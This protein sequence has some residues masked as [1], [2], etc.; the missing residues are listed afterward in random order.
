MSRAKQYFCSV[1]IFRYVCAILVVM[2]HTHP[3]AFGD[4]DS[5]ADAFSTDCVARIAVP[6]F[7]AVSGYFFAEKMNGDKARQFAIFRKSFWN[8]LRIYL[9][10]SCIYAVF[11]FCVWGKDD[12][13]GFLKNTVTD[14]FIHGSHF[15]FWYFTALLF[16]ICFA[17]LFYCLNLEKVA[18]ALGLALYLAYCFVLPAFPDSSVS[19]VLLKDGVGVVGAD[20][21]C[22]FLF[23]GFPYFSVGLAVRWI[24]SRRESKIPNPI[25][26][27]VVPAVAVG[28]AATWLAARRWDGIYYGVALFSVYPLV[29]GILLLFLQNSFSRGARVAGACRK[30]AN[31]T[32]YSHPILIWI[33]DKTLGNTAFLPNSLVKFL[34][35]A[36]VASLIGWAVFKINRPSFNKI[37]G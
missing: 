30:M 12:P 8:I 23:Y 25:L 1:D 35:V 33:F 17:Y 2:I 24:R 34:T 19:R 11:N 37:V 4:E 6:F 20:D 36:V 3:F 29:A 10:W 7:F 31:F 13:I 18:V 27:W 5:L 21:I 28:Y 15:H 26:F 14:F 32:Y 9:I 22:H 16:A